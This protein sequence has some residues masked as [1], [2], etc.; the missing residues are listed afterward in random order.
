[1]PTHTTRHLRLALMGLAT[2]ASRPAS[3]IVPCDNDDEEIARLLAAC[4]EEFALP[5]AHV[6]RPHLGTERLAQVRNN[7]IRY[8]LS[9]D[10]D[11]ASRLLFLDGDC[12]AASDT[13]DLHL[14]AG[15][16]HD[17]VV[18]YRINLTPQQTEGFD[19]RRALEGESPVEVTREQVRLLEARHRRYERQLRLKRLGLVKAHK[20]KP[21]GGHHSVSLA[22]YRRVN[23]HD[24]EYHTWG[25]EDDDFGRRVYRSGGTCSLIVRQSRV[26]HLYHPTRAGPRWHDR[27]N[28]RR[29]ARGG[30]VRCVSGLD[31]PRPQ[32]EPEVLLFGASDRVGLTR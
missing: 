15:D 7:A 28:A 32:P 17:L 20:P 6:R 5:I 31:S 4:A 19:E 18:A 24:E 25:T 27:E 12:F 26:L 3:V 2:Q 11:P 21:L 29:F 9:T 13:V 22:A 23:G 1:M 10:P 14:R 16:D 30:P 8:L